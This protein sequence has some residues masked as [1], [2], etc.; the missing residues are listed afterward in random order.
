MDQETLA[1]WFGIGKHHEHVTAATRLG[2]TVFQFFVAVYGGYFGAGIG[3]L[4]LSALAM[5]GLDDIH[6]MNAVKTLLAA[7]INGVSA[8]V[9][10]YHGNVHW[11]FALIM[12]VSAL[13]GGLAGAAAARRLNRHLVRSLVVAI[14]F[15]LAAF[16]FYQQFGNW[17]G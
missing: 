14:G 9:F 4:M 2:V 17:S 3:I 5:M 12:A 6:C 7:V 16:F 8:A 1:R 15:G 11:E 13:A 10:I